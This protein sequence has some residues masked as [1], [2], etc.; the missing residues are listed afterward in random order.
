MY[1]VVHAD[2]FIYQFKSFTVEAPLTSGSIHENDATDAFWDIQDSLLSV[3]DTIAYANKELC[4]FDLEASTSGPNAQFKVT[5]AF[6][7]A[8]LTSPPNCSPTFASR[9]ASATAFAVEGENP[10]SLNSQNVG[11]FWYGYGQGTYNTSNHVTG[12]DYTKPDA[13]TLLRQYGIRAYLGCNTQYQ[14]CGYWA[15]VTTDFGMP[16]TLTTPVMPNINVPGYCGNVDIY[17]SLWISDGPWFPYDFSVDP[18]L[19]LKKYLSVG[20]MDFY[21]ARIPWHINNKIPSGKTFYD[22][23]IAVV[24]CG[25]IPAKNVN[26][27]LPNDWTVQISHVY[28]VSAGVFIN[29][30]GARWIGLTAIQF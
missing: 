14:G 5:A 15:Y 16:Q 23:N 12:V 4:F 21:R 30:C 11:T 3:Y 25:C 2:T 20:M 22:F 24:N 7:R 18:D 1:A 8:A 29:D 9:Y 19:D 6:S 13:P 10:T 28:H 27:C 17:G 26:A